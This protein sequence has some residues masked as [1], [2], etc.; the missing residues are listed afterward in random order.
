MN[1]II[2]IMEKEFPN[3]IIMFEKGSFCNVYCEDSYV[4]SYLL[5]YKIKQLGTDVSCGFPKNSLNKVR[6]I[7]E[8]KKINYLVVDRSHSYEEDDKV[9]FKDN[10]YQ[11]VYEKAK[12]YVTAKMRLENISRYILNNIEN[13]EVVKII[14]KSE[15]LVNET[16]KVYSN[17]SC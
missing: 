4:I 6:S 1:K 12:K 5:D 11:E 7:L 15:D 14:E 17:K 13:E 3:Y 16:R 10:K 8:N 9:E 2:E